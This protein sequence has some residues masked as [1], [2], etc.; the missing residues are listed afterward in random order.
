[1]KS[2][3]GDITRKMTEN[4]AD[5]VKKPGALTEAQNQVKAPLAIKLN[6]LEIKDP[7]AEG[8]FGV[9][10]WGWHDGKKVAI[11][12]WRNK[13]KEGF[14]VEEVKMITSL[15]EQ[16]T[17]KFQQRIVIPTFAEWQD[18]YITI[19]PLANYGSLKNFLLNLVKHPSKIDDKRVL[20]AFQH[21]PV[22]FI[23]T[24]FLALEDCITEQHHLNHLHLDVSARNFLVYDFQDS[25]FKL[26]DKGEIIGLNNI[27]I[28]LTDHGLAKEIIHKNQIIEF[29][30]EHTVP[31]RWSDS[32]RMYDHK[33]SIMSDVF[34]FKTTM[35]TVLSLLLGESIE[36]FL[37]YLNPNNEN[38]Q[39]YKDNRKVTTNS[40]VLATYFQ[41]C[42][43]HSQKI[44]TKFQHSKNNNEQL[45]VKNAQACLVIIEAYKDYLTHSPDNYLLPEQE[46]KEDKQQLLKSSK[47]FEMI[48]A[49]NY[50]IDFDH[51]SISKDKL[52]NFNR[53]EMEEEKD[54]QLDN[55]Y[56]QKLEFK[57]EDEKKLDVENEGSGSPSRQEG[58]Y[59]LAPGSTENNHF[60]KEGSG[61]PSRPEGNYKF[62]PSTIENDEN[63]PKEDSDLA[64]RQQRSYTLAPSSTQS[65]Y[66]LTPPP[67]HV[68]SEQT[69]EEKKHS[70]K[71]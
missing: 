39:S 34:S 9:I 7:I 1:M 12:S 52:P 42:I 38:Y 8:N 17:Q 58:N 25:D 55:P 37:L 67:S 30:S 56:E 4:Q 32:A 57:K 19:S 43:N 18:A 45:K 40:Q 10:S 59:K 69:D 36:Q 61:S 33:V 23:H 6:S 62:A 50:Q 71:I 24:I 68:E 22:N 26:N 53:S 21:D 70:P 3:T 48:K 28:K 20:Q 29:S 64:S 49:N 65:D 16:A 14:D 13:F 2:S 66:V 35:V 41:N 47:Y 51:V 11:K 54:I 31:T 15:T 63:L 5:E 46:L 60:Q 44:I 27:P